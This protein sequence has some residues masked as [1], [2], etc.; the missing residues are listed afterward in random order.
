MMVVA[1]GGSGRWGKS[2]G[3][4]AWATGW[5]GGYAGVGDGGVG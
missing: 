2:G 4:Y 5:D 1:G 3:G